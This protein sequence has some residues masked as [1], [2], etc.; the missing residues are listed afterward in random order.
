MRK[1]RQAPL[2]IFVDTT[3]FY[4]LLDDRDESHDAAANVWAALAGR[5]DSLHTTNYIVVETTTLLQARLGVRAV[6]AFHDEL[7]PVVQTHIVDSSLHEA[8]VDL[9]FSESRR[10]LSL[11]DCSSFVFMRRSGIRRAFSFDRD[12]K[13]SG[14][15]LL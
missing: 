11:I 8:G 6:R 1:E 15:E 13:H 12:F 7:L 5:R 2:M 10:H 4:A 9:L 3:A 14:F